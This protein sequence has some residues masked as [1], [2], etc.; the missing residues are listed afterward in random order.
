MAKGAATALCYLHKVGASAALEHPGDNNVTTAEFKK[1]EFAGGVQLQNAIACIQGFNLI[2]TMMF[3]ATHLSS[4][5]RSRPFVAQQATIDLIG[6]G[7]AAI[8]VSDQPAE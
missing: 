3:V 4:I 1:S 8:L 2:A 5:G 7:Q 6:E